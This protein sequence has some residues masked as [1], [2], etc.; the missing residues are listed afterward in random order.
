MSYQVVDDANLHWIA[1][2]LRDDVDDAD[3]YGPSEP[4]TIVFNTEPQAGDLW[5]DGLVDWFD[6]LKLSDHWLLPGSSRGNDYWERADTDRNGSVDAV[7][8]SFL[9]RNWR[10]PLVEESTADWEWIET[11]FNY[12]LMDI[13]FPAGQSQIGY[14]IGESLTYKGQGI[15]I[16]TMDGGDTWTRLTPEGI[17]GLE[18]M[19]FADLHTGY[20]GGW[21]G[22]IIKTTDGG[23]TWDAVIGTDGMTVIA[24]IEFRDPNH[25]VLFEGGNVH[26]T[27]D[28]GQTWAAG[29]GISR[30]CHEVTYANEHTLFSAGNA[31]YIFKSIDGGHTWTTVYEGVRQDLLL[32]VDF[33]NTQYGIVVGDYSTVLTTVDGGATWTRAHLPGDM[34]LRSV[35]IFNPDI[36][37]LCGSPEYIFKTIDGGATWASDYNG[38]WE[39]AFN[40]VRFTDEGTGFICGSGGIVLRKA[41]P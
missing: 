2:R 34:L 27:E 15:I 39:E 12:I 40:R 6:L 36:A 7:D 26:V 23:A 18:A 28:G 32:G 10:T 29:T 11:G 21:D 25:G 31:G 19:S 17:P 35:F 24:D 5:V 9:A 41:G 37:Y 20:A 13:E 8:F 1:F 16:K 4:F 30:V 22:Y 33:L 38:N 3:R 14:A